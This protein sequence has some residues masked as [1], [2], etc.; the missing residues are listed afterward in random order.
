MIF[1]A[2]TELGVIDDGRAE[3]TTCERHR[4]HV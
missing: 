2:V 1:A 4:S 3:W